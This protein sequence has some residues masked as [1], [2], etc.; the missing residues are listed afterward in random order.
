MQ[1]QTTD[2]CVHKLL[3]DQ[4]DVALEDLGLGLPPLPLPGTLEGGSL[5]EAALRRYSATQVIP[6]ARLAGT[7]SRPRLLEAR[8]GLP[9]HRGGQQAEDLE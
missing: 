1:V 9:L 6:V 4:G 5:R 3:A 7:C 8:L 2:V